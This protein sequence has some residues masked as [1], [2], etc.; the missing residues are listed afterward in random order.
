MSEI[1]DFFISYNRA[2]KQWAEW[3][4]WT[5][6]EAGYSVVIQAWDF[7]PGGNFVLDM[8]K[9]AVESEKTIAVLSE[10]YL[11]S[12]FTQPEWAAAFVDDP[13]SLKRKLIPIRVK[14]CKPEGLLQSI[15][16]V[17]LVG[18]SPADAKQALL[19][20]LA[21]RAKPSQPP[22]FP[23]MEPDA[24]AASERVIVEPK[25]FPSALS[26]VQKVKEAAL[27]QQ[28][29]NLIADHGAA[30]QQLSGTSNAVERVRLERQLTAIAQ[31]MDRVAANLDDLGA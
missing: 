23:G 19:N 22:T 10:S 7:R 28:L 30:N 27:L 15:V 18:L 26:R 1:K 29:D 11:K 16:Y 3:I 9:A 17:D 31:E 24:T 20:S 8:Q 14:E 25:A 13:E 5:L 12:S 21:Q 4:A 2:D 6:E